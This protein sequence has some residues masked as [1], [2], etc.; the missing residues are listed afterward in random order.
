MEG[1]SQ[2]T[3]LP[4]TGHQV[5]QAQERRLQSL[6]IFDDPDVTDLFSDVE[7]ATAIPLS[8]ECSGT[9]EA[10]GSGDL[11]QTDALLGTGQGRQAKKKDTLGQHF[12][13][14][15]TLHWLTK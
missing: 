13:C 7:S 2:E 1:E 11:F 8:L 9:P 10:L 3:S 6:A 5:F 12:A 15:S 14:I 4:T